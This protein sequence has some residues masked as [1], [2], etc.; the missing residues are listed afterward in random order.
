MAFAPKIPTSIFPAGSWLIAMDVNSPPPETM[1]VWMLAYTDRQRER[2]RK[3]KKK[4]M[5]GQGSDCIGRVS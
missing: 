1:M 4:Q 2:D 5:E 3:K